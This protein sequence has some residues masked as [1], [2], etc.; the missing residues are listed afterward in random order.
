VNFINDGECERLLRVSPLPAVPTVLEPACLTGVML[1]TF[2]SLCLTTRF[3][4]ST[5]DVDLNGDRNVW[6]SGRVDATVLTVAAEGRR[7]PSADALAIAF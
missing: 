6:R 3:A 1:W 5:A 4:A 7:D 2:D